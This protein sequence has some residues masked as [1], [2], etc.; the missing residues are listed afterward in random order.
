VAVVFPS[1]LGVREGVLVA[2]LTVPNAPI[3]AASIFHRLLGLAAEA[4]LAGVSRARA[5]V[6]ARRAVRRTGPTDI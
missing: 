4:T 6:D 2:V 3:L 1:G 5:A